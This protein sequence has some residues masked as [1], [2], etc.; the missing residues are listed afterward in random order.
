MCKALAN[1]NMTLRPNSR[2]IYISITC[3][4]FYTIHVHDNIFYENIYI[5]IA[6][7]D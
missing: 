7:N 2:Q 3:M 6:I 1:T 5:Y 4:T